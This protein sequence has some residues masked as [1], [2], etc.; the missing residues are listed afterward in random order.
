MKK[1][2][3]IRN[4]LFHSGSVESFGDLYDNLIRVRALTERM[5]LQMLSWNGKETWNW[6]D[7]ELHRVNA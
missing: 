4:D 5:I 6:C 1:A 7:Q 2:V 3:R